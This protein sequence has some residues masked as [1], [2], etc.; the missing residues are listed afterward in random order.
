VLATAKPWVR[1]Q[2]VQ[3]SDTLYWLLATSLGLTKLTSALPPGHGTGYFWSRLNRAGTKT[4]N[5]NGNGNNDVDMM[6]AAPPPTTSSAANTAVLSEGP[7]LPANTAT[8]N[9][10]HTSPP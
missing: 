9:V 5:A 8:T 6:R 3:R 10:L 1:I 4:A 7:V 2:L